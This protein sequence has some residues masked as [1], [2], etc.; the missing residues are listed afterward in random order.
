MK[1]GFLVP[2]GFA[3]TRQIW[4]YACEVARQ[5]RNNV[6][7]REAVLGKPVNQQQNRT[8]SESSVGHARIWHGDKI[9]LGVELLNVTNSKVPISFR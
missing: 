2:A 8:L 4:H 9:R 6:A 3:Q 5:L 7:P 1:V